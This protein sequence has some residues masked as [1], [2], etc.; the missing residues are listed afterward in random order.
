MEIMTF[1]TGLINAI[2]N[3]TIQSWAASVDWNSLISSFITWFSGLGVTGILIF[4]AIVGNIA[5]FVKKILFTLVFIWA[6]MLFLDGNGG[7][8][9][10]FNFLMKSTTPA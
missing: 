10:L 9:G 3:G 4:W 6:L 2:I 1:I 5:D 8:T 7:M